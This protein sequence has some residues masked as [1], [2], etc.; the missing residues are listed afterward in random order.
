MLNKE[1]KAVPSVGLGVVV[2]SQ[3]M[4]PVPCIQTPVLAPSVTPVPIIVYRG[5]QWVMTQATSS[6]QPCACSR[7]VSELP[8]GGVET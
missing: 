4:T 5:N 2:K 8:A 7:L 3:A 6:S 1:S